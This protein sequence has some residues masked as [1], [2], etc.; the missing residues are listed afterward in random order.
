MKILLVGTGITNLTLGG[1]LVRNVHKIVIIDRKDHIGGNCFDYFDENSID[2][3]AYGT[4]IFHTDNTEVWRFLSQFTKWY[5]YQHE[6]KALVDGQ[7][8]PVPFNFNSIEQLFP[9]QMAERMI[10]A[11]LSEFE[12][13]KKIPILKLRES[14]NPDLQ[15]LAKYVYEKIF[16]HY[17]EKQ[18]GVRPEDLD[19]LVT[20]R[21]PVFVG[22][23]NRY[24]QAKYQGIPLEGYT[25]MFEKMVDHPN[26]E[27]RLN[28][29]FDKSMLDE[30]DHCFFSGA[31]DE[32]FD[33]KREFPAVS[34]SRRQEAR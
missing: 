23:D 11:L 24:F 34:Y 29:E 26:I 16:L 25:R 30:Y 13:N 9:K 27:V 14:K 17:T 7:L 20:G 6:V 19:P 32:F 1:S 12:F 31:I 33:Y 18:W 22:R 8:V 4:H 28:T 15:F 10:A 3:H 2:I 21:V 5:P